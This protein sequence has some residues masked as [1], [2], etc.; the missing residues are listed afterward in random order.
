MPE[1]A[2]A[3]S[4]M[5]KEPKRA[6]AC[7]S[8]GSQQSPVWFFSGFKK[9][10]KFK[11]THGTPFIA[12]HLLCVINKITRRY[13]FSQ[14]F[15]HWIKWF[16]VKDRENEVPDSGEKQYDKVIRHQKGRRIRLRQAGKR[17]S[18]D[19]VQPFYKEKNR[20]TQPPGCRYLKK[21]LFWQYSKG[22]D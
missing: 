17:Q 11:K 8:P 4:T 20:N 18:R 21:A 5:C 13:S 16:D 14:N 7:F 9:T 10:E 1:A 3:K 19:L 15:R 22:Q 12:L 2:G 6:T